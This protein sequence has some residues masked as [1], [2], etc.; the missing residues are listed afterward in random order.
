MTRALLAILVLVAPLAASSQQRDMAAGSGTGVIAGT[1]WSADATPQPVRRALVTISGDASPARSAVTD[2]AGRFTFAGLPAGTFTLTARKAA[3]LPT[4]YGASR[5]GRAGS[6]VSLAAGQRAAVTLTMFR[7][8]VIAGVLRDAAGVP[9]SGVQVSAIDLG[10]EPTALDPLG[11]G[12]PGSTVTD[13]RGGYRIYG[14][15]PGE[16][17][18]WA[19]PATS[20][21]G[22]VGGSGE[23]GARSDADT[24]AALAALVQRRSGMTAPAA[25]PAGITA[26]PARTPPPPVPQPETI[27]F[28]PTYFPGTSFFAE[29]ARF[30]LAAGDV[31]DGVNFV[32]DRVRVSSIE[33]TVVGDVPNLAAVQLSL[34]VDGPRVGG[35]FN[36]LGIVTK[37]PDALGQF[38]YSNVPPGKYRI[39]ARG[40]LGPSDAAS[41][42]TPTVVNVQTVGSGRSGAPAAGD[43]ARGGGEVLF[44]VAD[45]EVRGQDLTGVALALQPGATLS[46]TLAFDSDAAPIPADLT[47]I[48]IALSIL[49][50]SYSSNSGGTTVGNALSSIPAVNAAADGTF[51][52]QGIGPGLFAL[53]C[54]LPAEL[55]KVW[56]LRSAMVDGRDLLDGPIEPVPGASITGVRLTLSDK[57]TQIAGSLQTASGQPTADYYVIAF[58]TDRSHWRAGSR[59]LLSSRPATDGRFV[60]DDL[61][62]GEYFIAA[63][64]DVDPLEWQSAMFLEQVAPAAVTVSVAEGQKTVQD[65]RIR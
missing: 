55:S 6:A 13:D 40:R 59:R 64:T 18:V 14:L 26:T 29:A 24:D 25:A 38:R 65:L 58:S 36:T 2:D 33:G 19:T 8:A 39:V 52:I 49:G 15:S 31:R 30:R 54:L 27:G 7:G 50:G 41:S 37:P 3:Y 1:V 10:G 43:A 11:S 20:G 53:S 45:V 16:Y 17:I 35:T 9:L 46:G 4:A 28:A 48:R 21:I 63:L 44:A 51:R 23:I 5:P 56:K 32:V 57:R 12:P 34:I 42:T 61:P 47:G 22:G 62:A 60:F